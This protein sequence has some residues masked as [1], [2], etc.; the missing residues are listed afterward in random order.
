MPAPD[1]TLSDE[2]LDHVLERFG[3]AARPDPTLAGLRALFAAWNRRV[4]FDNVRKMVALHEGTSG[5]LP[6]DDATGFFTAW[7][8]DGAGG[9][10]WAVAGA[11]HALLTSVGFR[12]ERGVATMMV[13][14]G[15]PPNHGTVVVRIDAARYAVDPSILH[16]EPLRLDHGARI[17][18]GAWGA[19]RV[20]ADG[21]EVI[22]WR[23]PRRPQGLDCRIDRLGADRGHFAALHEATRRWSPFNFEL[24]A[25]THRGDTMIASVKGHRIVRDASG[26]ESET[27]FEGTERLHWLVDELGITESLAVR[28]PPDRATPPPPPPPVE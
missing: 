22:R 7:L 17:E 9:T 13:A 2:L 27:P 20:R 6:G 21:H 18:H 12:A 25:Q 8:R 14:P 10:C 5:P 15:I 19:A 1:D 16:H 24:Y 28:L 3:F 11:L 26:A 23:P 4:P